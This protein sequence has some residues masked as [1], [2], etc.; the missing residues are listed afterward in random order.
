MLIEK[1]P[2]I[3]EKIEIIDWDHSMDFLIDETK[4]R[5]CN[6]LKIPKNIIY[7]IPKSIISGLGGDNKNI[8]RSLFKNNKEFIEARFFHMQFWLYVHTLM[9]ISSDETFRKFMNLIPIIMI[10]LTN[11]IT[12]NK[13]KRFI[14]LLTR[15]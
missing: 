7:L 13:W 1:K 14:K 12:S 9:M 3:S 2:L 4:K 6:I 8:K 15:W 5:I 10:I 11:M